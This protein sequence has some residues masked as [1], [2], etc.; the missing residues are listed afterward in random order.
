[1]KAK[2]ALLWVHKIYPLMTGTCFIHIT[3][4]KSQKILA[5][6]ILFSIVHM[7]NLLENQVPFKLQGRKWLYTK[8]YNFHYTKLPPWD[9]WGI[10]IRL[11]RKTFSMESAAFT[12]Y[13]FFFFIPLLFFKDEFPYEHLQQK[14][15]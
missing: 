13:F 2:P 1:M 11:G 7:K 8:V 14:M 3:K 6:E 5:R 4:L 12:V 10:E 15:Y 9:V